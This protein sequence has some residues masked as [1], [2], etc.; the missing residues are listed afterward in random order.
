MRRANPNDDPLYDVSGA[1]SVL[2]NFFGL[3]I[4][5]AN[6]V[7]FTAEFVD[8]GP[9]LGPQKQSQKVHGLKFVFYGELQHSAHDDYVQR[10]TYRINEHIT[11][12][13]YEQ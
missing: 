7:S 2:G 1:D 9:L 5:Q 8:S 3:A 6:K 4:F 11:I 12:F 10:G 13:R